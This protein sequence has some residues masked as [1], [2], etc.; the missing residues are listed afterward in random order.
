MR[1]EIKVLGKFHDVL[2]SGC[3]RRILKCSFGVGLPVAMLNQL[4]S[5]LESELQAIASQDRQPL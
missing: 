5:V 4:C 3:R 2:M 1:N